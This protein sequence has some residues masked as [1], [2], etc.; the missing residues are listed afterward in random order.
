MDLPES[1]LQSYRKHFRDT[2]ETVGSSLHAVLDH[3]GKLDDEL[4]HLLNRI[5]DWR[6]R[7][8]A[9]LLEPDRFVLAYWGV[10]SDAQNG[11][12]HQYFLNSSGDLWPDL[13]RLLELGG[14][15]LAESHFRRVLSYFPSS[16]PSMDREQRTAQLAAIDGSDQSDFLNPFDTLDSEYYTE[17]MYPDDETLF[18]ALKALDDVDFVPDPCEELEADS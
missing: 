14:D 8:G 16:S 4:W 12:F 2:R 10:R 7:V 1:V 5:A 11:G 13:L 17:C 3:H 9:T 18:R 6:S 15:Q